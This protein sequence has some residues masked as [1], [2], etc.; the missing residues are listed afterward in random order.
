MLKSKLSISPVFV[1]AILAL[2]IAIGNCSIQLGRRSDDTAS[3]PGAS[4]TTTLPD[5][6]PE[7]FSRLFEVW[8]AL[9]RDHL[10]R[11]TL[12]PELLSEGAIRG[13]LEALDDPYASYLSPQ[14]FEMDSEDFAGAFEGIG[15]EVTMREGKITIVAPIPDTPAEKAGVRPGDVILAINGEST[16]GLSLF[17]AV[18]TIRGARGESVDLLIQHR[19]G[20]EPVNLTI[21][22]DVIKVT[23]VKFRMLVGRIAHLRITSFSKTTEQDVT[24]ALET[25]ERL[26]ARGL[27]LDVRNNPGGLLDSVVDVTGHFVDE[28]LVLYEIDGNG[29]RRDWNARSEGLARD[30]PMVLL[31]NQFSASGSEVLAGAVKDT[32]RAVLIGEQTFGKGSVNTLRELSDGS[33]LYFTIARWYTPGGTLIEGE[34]LAPDIEI[35]ESEDFL[36]DV[37]LDKAIEILEA[38]V[39]AIEQ[40]RG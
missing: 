13:M 14:Q 2:A 17:E 29:T 34:G 21:V 35:P 19:T 26:G 31:V 24:E 36:E 5:S 22:R 30:I 40:E 23:S 18:N 32:D 7:E 37:Q 25:M 9:K 1:V 12:N 4:G 11:D 20:G 10:E 6:V 39:A 16:N 8:S 27:V 28:G 15:A 3:A 33:G 38:K